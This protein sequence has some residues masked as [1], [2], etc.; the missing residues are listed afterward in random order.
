MGLKFFFSGRLECYL[1]LRIL[2]SGPHFSVR[3][4]K[5]SLCTLKV[6]RRTR[7]WSVALVFVFLKVILILHFLC[8]KLQLGI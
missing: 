7:V 8:H 4:C 3:A 1:F 6:D 5:V 2:M